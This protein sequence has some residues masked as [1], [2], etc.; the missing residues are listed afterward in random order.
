MIKSS[1]EGR[2]E[3]MHLLL[4]WE[5]RLNRGRL[6]VL[7]DL[8]PTRASEWI[9]EFG[10]RFPE[11]MKWNSKTRSYEVLPGFFVSTSKSRID[12]SESMAKYLAIVGLRNQEIEGVSHVALQAG[13]HD[14]STPSPLVF[15]RLMEGIRTC[16]AVR[17]EYRS[18]QD[19]KPHSRDIA[20]HSLVRSGRRWH[21]RAY[22]ETHHAFRDYALGRISRIQLLERGDLPGV[23]DDDAWNTPVP[24]RLLP[25]PGLTRDQQAVIRFEYFTDAASRVEICRG[26]MVPYFIQDVRAALLDSEQPPQYQIIVANLAEVK[27]WLWMP[28]KR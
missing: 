12:L 14:L 20:P 24:V 15:S 25:H 17:I 16:Q 8:S 5:G 3:K 7:F 9:R 19:P 23:E 21:V 4:L 10:E 18:M 11:S 2:L 13:F 27:S 26:P 22:S 28:S 1:N 6:I